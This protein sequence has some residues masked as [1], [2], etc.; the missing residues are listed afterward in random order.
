[1]IVTLERSSLAR[2]AEIELC[3][4]TCECDWMRM[5]VDFQN[6]ILLRGEECETPKNPYF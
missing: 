5:C 3:R 4:V 2:Q 1:M 6:E